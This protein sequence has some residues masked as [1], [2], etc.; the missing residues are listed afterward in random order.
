[1]TLYYSPKITPQLV[2]QLQKEPSSNCREKK[3]TPFTLYDVKTFVT[4]L[5]GNEKKLA[6]IVV[7]SVTLSM[8][9]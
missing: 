1:M 3:Q 2:E 7:G 6:D 8:A 4:E 5:Y 9:Y